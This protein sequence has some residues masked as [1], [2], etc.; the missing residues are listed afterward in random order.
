MKK[1]SKVKQN[2]L[3][4]AWVCE[5][6]GAPYCDPMLLSNKTPAGRKIN[7]RK[8]LGL[9]IGCGQKECKCKNKGRK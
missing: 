4:R 8:S 7:K 9:C 1:R 3:K 6:C 2:G 5:H